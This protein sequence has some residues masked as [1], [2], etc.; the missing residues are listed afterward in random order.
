MGLQAADGPMDHHA[1][2]GHL[3]GRTIC[4]RHR[5]HPVEKHLEGAVAR[6]PRDGV[7]HPLGLDHV[8]QQVQ[9]RASRNCCHGGEI[10]PTTEVLKHNSL[11]QLPGTGE[12]S[13]SDD[14]QIGVEYH[15]Q[16]VLVPDS[17]TRAA[18]IRTG[19]KC[20]D[21]TRAVAQLG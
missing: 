13:M 10:G 4:I 2:V 15:P 6:S 17:P 16:V 5:L 19:S 12:T 3:N 9:L 8:V 20:L 21:D 14:P 1:L 18:G 7:H 11:W